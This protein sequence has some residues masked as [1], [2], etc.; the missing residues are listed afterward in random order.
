LAERREKCMRLRI[1][2]MVRF[3]HDE[4]KT[5]YRVE[6]FVEGFLV[7]LAGM[8]IPV[9]PTAFSLTTYRW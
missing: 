3:K 7:K 4:T 1:G 8:D 9:D 6:Q 5:P 2:D